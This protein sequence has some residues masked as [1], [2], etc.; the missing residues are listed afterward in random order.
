MATPLLSVCAASVVEPSL[1]VTEPVGTPRVDF[2]VAVNVTVCPEFAGL[3]DE[4][5][6]VS[7]VYPF[8]TC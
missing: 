3:S 1:N 6:E 7:V 4:V 8:T 2:T 5:I